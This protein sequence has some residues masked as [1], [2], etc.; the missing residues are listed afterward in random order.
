MQ[1]ELVVEEQQMQLNF[2]ARTYKNKRAVSEFLS[3]NQFVLPNTIDEAYARSKMNIP[4]FGFYYIMVWSI[5]LVFV[6][7]LCPVFIV[8]VALSAAMLYIS[9]TKAKI[10]EIE[11]TPMHA[12]YSCIGCNL[13]LMLVFKSIAHSFLMV[14]SFSSIATIL[15][16]FHASLFR[17]TDGDVIE[18]I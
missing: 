18:H 9:S 12:L 14:L 6:M 3:F 7:L 16:L 5:S 15:V 17:D 11:I 13:F 10:R 2:L 8:P 4:R 1:G